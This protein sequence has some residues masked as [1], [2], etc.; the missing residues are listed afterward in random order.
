MNK[1][2]LQPIDSLMRIIDK[3]VRETVEH[4]RRTVAARV[5]LRSTQARE[6]TDV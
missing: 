4:D 1:H 3:R 6:S 2:N 5:L